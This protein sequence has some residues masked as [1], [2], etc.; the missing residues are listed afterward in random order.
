VRKLGRKSPATY[1]TYREFCETRPGFWSDHDSS[2]LDK[3][4]PRIWSLKQA[5]G[6][7]LRPE[8]QPMILPQDPE[9]V[10]LTAFCLLS[11]PRILVGPRQFLSGQDVAKNLVPKTGSWPRFEA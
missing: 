1:E 4:L 8:N 7:V 2:F 11:V 5:H 10:L 6:L 9:P 3:M